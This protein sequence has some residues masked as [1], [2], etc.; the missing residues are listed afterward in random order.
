M[1]GYYDWAPARPLTQPLVLSGFLGARLGK[2]ANVLSGM[3]GYRLV[4]V[5]RGVEHLAGQTLGA[6]MVAEG[7]PAI[8]AYEKSIM[9]QALRVPPPPIIA[10][11]HRSLLDRD[12]RARI[13]RET[14]HVYVKV[15][16]DTAVQRVRRAIGEN[17][18][19][20]YAWFEG[21][22]P[23]HDDLR[24]RFLPLRPAY[25]AADIVVDGEARAGT[26]AEAILQALGI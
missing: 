15:S 18:A 4:D 1:S 20:H 25:E 21:V 3:T 13:A 23:D 24:K 14:T 22:I 10:L 9:D 5:P 6:L 17:G 7:I 19:T 16:L 8:E 11:S 26:V 12:L 2:V